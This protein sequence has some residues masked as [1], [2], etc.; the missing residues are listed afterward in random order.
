M[1]AKRLISSSAK[2]PL[3]IVY[4]SGLS[5]NGLLNFASEDFLEEYWHADKKDIKAALKND[6]NFEEDEL[7]GISI[8][9]Y[10][11][12]KSV[13]PQKSLSDTDIK[14]VKKI[15]E[16][17]FEYLGAEDMDLDLSTEVNDETMAVASDFDITPTIVQDLEV[18]AKFSVNEKIGRFEPDLAILI[19]PGEVEEALKPFA[20]HFDYRSDKKLKITGYVALCDPSYSELGA[21]RAQVIASLLTTK[22]NIPADKIEVHGEGGI[23][24]L[25]NVVN[26]TCD[27]MD[28][29]IMAQ[30]R[31]VIIEVIKE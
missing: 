16:S 11:L 13:S 1:E 12:G 24:P 23:P 25:E 27:N 30:R 20:K 29:E 2:N 26:N 19:N 18:G 21:A 6:G 31:T 4:G 9:W 22:F 28:P 7:D 10:N 15:Y 3:I 5:D 14:K 8:K 17:V